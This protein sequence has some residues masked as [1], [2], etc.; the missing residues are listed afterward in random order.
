MLL[1]FI[2]SVWANDNYELLIVGDSN[3]PV[4]FYLLPFSYEGKGINASYEIEEAIKV[5]LSSAGLFSM[6]MRIEPPQH[7]IKNTKWR[8]HD[9]RFVIEGKLY[10][11]KDSIVLHLA[12]Y[13]TLLQ[14]GYTL[15]GALVPNQLQTS[16]GLF[17]DSVYRSFFYAAFTNRKTLQEVEHEDSTQT[18]Y[19]HHIVQ[20]YKSHWSPGETHGECLV[21]LQQLPGGNVLTYELQANCFQNKIFAEEILSLLKRV[22]QLPYTR[23]EE[24]FSKNL[25]ITFSR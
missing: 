14:N 21:N 6:P 17:A 1:F 13:D 24:Q 20:T 16:A 5:A 10:E 9:I 12:I 15:S 19:L 3:Q 23:Y 11:Q 22:E 25:A 18:N 7:P 2:P 8:L 4:K